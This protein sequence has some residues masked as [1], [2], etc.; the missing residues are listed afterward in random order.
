MGIE[1]PVDDDLNLPKILITFELN[2]AWSINYT[3][4]R[5][6]QHLF[7]KVEYEEQLLY[8]KDTI[9][10]TSQKNTNKKLFKKYITLKKRK[11]YYELS[12]TRS[13][14]YLSRYR[15]LKSPQQFQYN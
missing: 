15:M 12:Q 7:P 9:F 10:S 5:D 3:H 8:S 4:P 14:N 13:I 11:E 2:Q 6:K 1:K